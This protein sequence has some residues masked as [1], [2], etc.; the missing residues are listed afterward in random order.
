MREGTE[1][2]EHAGNIETFSLH[3][4]Q[5]GFIGYGS[6]ARCLRPLLAPFECRIS[7]YDPWLGAGYLRSQAVEPVDLEQLLV[8]SRVIFVLASPT[9]E[10]SALLSRPLLQLIQ[11]DAV[12]VLISRAHVVDFNALT[13]LLLAGRFKAAIDVF[14]QEPLDADHPIRQASNAVLSAHRAGS[15]REVLWELGDMVVDDLE[16]IARGLPPQRLQSA[17]PEII[18][19]YTSR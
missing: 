15:V 12:L 14:P 9:A 18:A 10:N 11:P 16:A 2:W 1:E 17:Q 8:R 5:V 7:V 6:L 4:K 19:R 13:E 3:R